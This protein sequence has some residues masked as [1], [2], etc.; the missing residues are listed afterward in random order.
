MRCLSIPTGGFCWFWTKDFEIISVQYLLDKIRWSGPLF[1]KKI[2]SHFPPVKRV[3][4]GLRFW[5]KSFRF[6]RP[7]GDFCPVGTE[8]RKYENLSFKTVWTV[9]GGTGEKKFQIFLAKQPISL[10]WILGEKS[11]RFFWPNGDFCPVGTEGKKNCKSFVKNRQNPPVGSGE[12]KFAETVSFGPLPR[13][14]V[15]GQKFS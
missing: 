8:E 11:F 2:S 4:F 5:E 3:R 9:K 1:R 12:R 13:L 10:Q 14:P 15:E 7:N 6:L